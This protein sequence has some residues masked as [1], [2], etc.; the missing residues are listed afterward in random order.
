MVGFVAVDIFRVL[1]HIFFI[2]RRAHTYD[3]DINGST[4]RRDVKR[5]LPAAAG[6]RVALG[7]GDAADQGI[8][9]TCL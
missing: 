7:K 8:G 4:D 9:A 5:Q 1:C 6:K 3:A 2:C